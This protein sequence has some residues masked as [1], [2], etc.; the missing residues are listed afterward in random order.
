[1]KILKKL[2][3]FIIIVV[4]FCGLLLK[5]TLA[6]RYKEFI[7]YAKDRYN[8]NENDED[9][10]NKTLIKNDKPADKK[11]DVPNDSTQADKQINEH[12]NIIKS[13]SN[14]ELSNEL[15]SYNYTATDYEGY[16]N[17]V[18]RS[19]ENFE[20]SVSI[21]VN[22]YN[23][24]TYS[25]SVINNILDD[26]YDIDYG[27]QGASGTIY[28]DGSMYVVNIEFKYKLNKNDMIHMRDETKAKAIQIISRIITPK[29]NDLNKE[30]AI[31]N[32]IVNNT[33]Y[34]YDNY[35][36]GTLSQ[37][38]FTDYGVLIQGRAVCEG[39]SKA[40]FKLLNMAGVQCIV[41][42]GTGNG[43]SHAWNIV[44]INGKYTQV[45]ATF[46]DPVTTNSENILSYNYFDISDSQ[47]GKDH[48]W[49]I[50]KY[51]KCN[52]VKYNKN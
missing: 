17:V 48:K 11:I 46:D 10:I 19:L 2:S 51:P 32:Y 5:N 8:T 26:H 35:I 16:Y 45:D 9:N 41:V 38:S 14:K 28:S 44:K 18:K 30:L 23:A 22:N 13:A 52:T 7:T 12:S 36:K 4:I 24:N 1:M 39:Y 37:A 29:M 31:H 33:V 20:S 27:V 3:I 43:E 21:R 15:D 34:D 40:M 49:S 47:M 25:L 6:D 50:K 42:K